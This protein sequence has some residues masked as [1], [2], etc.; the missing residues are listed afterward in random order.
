MWAS[1]GLVKPIP[2]LACVD[3]KFI[4]RLK[5]LLTSKGIFYVAE[6]NSVLQ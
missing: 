5:S 1:P 6:C 3:K 4:K 2:G